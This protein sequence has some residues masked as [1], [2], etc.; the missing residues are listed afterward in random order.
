MKQPDERHLGGE[1]LRDSRRAARSV[2]D[3]PEPLVSFAGS[4]A[5][6][7]QNIR[8]LSVALAIMIALLILTIIA[9]SAHADIHIDKSVVVVGDLV[10]V[11]VLPAYDTQTLIIITPNTTYRFVGGISES[12]AFIPSQTGEHIIRVLDDNNIVDSASFLVI[13]EN[14]RPPAQASAVTSAPANEAAFAVSSTEIVVDQPLIIY[15]P[16]LNVQAIGVDAPDGPHIYND[17][18]RPISYLPSVAGE[19]H[20]WIQYTNGTRA[21]ILVKVSEGRAPLAAP[22]NISANTPANTP[23][24]APTNAAP[25]PTDQF[26]IPTPT[27]VKR[28]G[29][30]TEDGRLV[31][32][33]LV[34]KKDGVTLRQTTAATLDPTTVAAGEYDLDVRTNGRSLRSVEFR[35]L[36]YS[37]DIHIGLEELEPGMVSGGQERAIEMF[38]IDPS[39]V[40]FEDGSLTFV[41]VGYEL[42]KCAEYDFAARACAGEN[43][44]VMDLTPGQAY[45]IAFNSTDP[46]YSQT[47]YL[48]N[49]NFDADTSG[50][51]TLTE[52]GNAPTFNWV[53][54]D[55]AQSGIA[56]I[57]LSG[58]NRNT[59]AHYRQNWT[60][61]IPAG[62][63]LIG[64]NFSAL[65]RVPQYA[66]S[67]NVTLDIMNSTRTISYC[68]NLTGFTTNTSWASI[69]KNA[70]S[71]GCNLGNF[72]N[73]TTYAFVLRCRMR[74]TTTG[75]EA[76]RWDNASVV[77]WY[78][79]TAAPV[80]RN[81][82]DSPDPV[83]YG[84]K[85]NTTVNITDNIGVNTTI[86]EIN[87]TNFTLTKSTG[88]I[89]YN[90]TFSTAR[91]LGI[92][93]YKVFAN[94]SNSNSITNNSASLNF[95]IRDV[96]APNITLLAPQ[97][98]TYNSSSVLLALYNLSDQVGVSNCSL[99]VNSATRNSTLSPALSTTLNLSYTVA[100]D[101]AYLWN[102]TCN[103]TSD[104]R[105]TTETRLWIRDTTA[106]LI[107][108][109]TPNNTATNNPSV[110]FNYTPQDPTLRNCSLW[111]NFS[112]IWA[113]N[114]STLSPNN[115]TANLFTAITLGHGHYR[116]N[117]QC[118][119][120]ASNNGFN[121]TN[122]TYR[123]DLKAP[124]WSGIA[125]TP[126]SG[127][128]YA[129]GATYQFNIS[130]TDDFVGV[131]TTNLETNFSGSLGNVTPTKNGN[132]FTYTFTDR[133][134]G[135]YQYQWY[136]NDSVGNPNQTGA[137]TYTIAKTA[138]AVNLTLNSTYQNRSVNL[139]DWLNLT[140]RMVTP[141]SGYIE[142]YLDG[143]R[144]NNGTPPLSN[145]TQFTQQKR[146]NVTLIYPTTQNYSEGR[147][148]LFVDVVDTIPPRVSLGNPGIGAVT[149]ST[150]DFYFTPSDN[151]DIGNC[152][153]YIDGTKNN[154]KDVANNVQDFITVNGISD[155]P[156][157]WDVNCSDTSNN[158]A[159]NG[160]P[161]S[162]TVDTTPPGLFDLSAPA[163]GTI[164][165]NLS[166]T[167][168]W[169]QPTEPNFD[170]YTLYID[171]D[172]GF[173]SPLPLVVLRPI[174]NTS[175]IPVLPDQTT[176]YWKVIAFDNASNSRQSTS[177]FNYT[178][179]ATPPTVS[180]NSP[181]NDSYLN[182]TSIRLTYTPNDFTPILN[183]SLYV[184]NTLNQ[185]NTTIVRGAQ[186]NFTL[187]IANN[188]YLWNIRCFDSARN[189]YTTAEYLLVID[190]VP[191]QSFTLTDPGNNS[192]VNTST[193]TY[194]WTATSESHFANYTLEVSDNDTF[195]YLNYTLSATVSVSN[196]SR[197][198]SPALTDGVWYWRATAY[199]RA[200]NSITM[201][202]SFNVDTTPPSA[203]DLLLPY[204]N[205]QSR[206]DL[207]LFQWEQSNDANFANYTLYLS[208][209]PTFAHINYTNGTYSKTAT[210][211]SLKVGQNTTLWWRVIAYDLANHSTNST[212]TF[213]Y[214]P[215][216]LNPNVTLIAPFN[217]TTITTSSLVNFQFNIT[218]VGEI[219]NCSLY[220]DGLFDNSINLP[221][222][223]S[224][225]TI[226]SNQEN[227]P[228]YW[229][230]NCLDKANNT[231]NSTAWNFTMNVSVPGQI[232]YESSAGTGNYTASA[233]INLTYARD[234]VENQVGY[235]I[236]RN[237]LTTAVSASY[238]LN[239]SSMILYNNTIVNFSGV[240]SQTRSD[241]FYVTWKLFII[242]GSGTY[243]I[244]QY[245][246]DST[247]GA[248]IGTTTKKTITAGCTY[249]GGD[250]FYNPGDTL[251]LVIDL[252]SNAPNTQS[253]THY[254]EGTSNSS[255]VFK[256]YKLGVLL[257]NLTNLT[258]PGINESSSYIEQC[259][260][261]CRDGY[262]MSTDVYLQLYNGTAWLNISTTGNL[263]LN[264]TQLNPVSL[265]NH[266]TSS[267]INFSLYGS[268]YSYNNTIR[269]FATSTYDQ[270][271]SAQKNVSV[272]DRLPPNVTLVSPGNNAAYDPQNITFTYTVGDRRL[273]NCSLWGNFSGPWTANQTNTSPAN[274]STNSFTPI[275]L[276]Y[277]VYLWNVLCYD[278]AKNIG[279]RS[280]NSTLYIAGDLEITPGNITLSD[281]SPVEGENLTIYANI[282]NRAN[283]TESAVVVQFWLGDPYA[284]G[285]Q[286]GTD[287][288][289]SL[290]KYGYNLTNVTWTATIGQ[291]DIYVVVDPPNGSGLI[292]ESNENNNMASRPLFISL[293]QVYYG[294]V[295]GTYVLGTSAN[296]TFGNWTLTGEAG[297][298]YI[299]STD[300]TQGINWAYLQALGRN[301]TNSTNANT[302]NDFEELDTLLGTGAYSD[303][304]N[305]TYT[306]GGTPIAVEEFTT[307]NRNITDVPVSDSSTDGNF[308]TGILWDAD[309]SSNSYYDT[310]DKED[311]VFA[312]RIHQATGSANGV[313]DYE[314]KVPSELKSYKGAS[315]TVTFYYEIQ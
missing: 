152:T 185:S 193:P 128:A 282:T 226:G 270:N 214:T 101:G 29:I 38:A 236:I 143:V 52:S 203:F 227:G 263:T 248:T 57:N 151:V 112:S 261:T 175:Y 251:T 241:A 113:L 74:T 95:T 26:S 311:I 164:T 146:Y 54:S 134:A 177:T 4:V 43:V 31:N 253:F 180:I 191:P 65:W 237:T 315:G 260:V 2:T 105:N 6:N 86:V 37:P 124:N 53:N 291:H 276:D 126:A 213:R 11:S 114:Q 76:C 206:D 119:D 209:T 178:T 40:T 159:F 199:D 1:A 107:L 88:D 287:R 56:Q 8:T 78:N 184:N 205:N 45:T 195:S 68:S 14:E 156:H 309:D 312:T 36:K 172:I 18:A 16:T 168:S 42:Y 132:V 200:G 275:Y 5:Y 197:T 204:D 279:M 259:N 17:A 80:L 108:L 173:G 41:A 64:I 118:Y 147:D 81:I 111:G 235:S 280:T 82:A 90:D 35:K 232:L 137:L 48:T 69:T 140:A 87:G 285:T 223:N 221:A 51:T 288:T 135:T 102:I 220:I 190:T 97:N 21:E 183:C 155:G 189:N 273:S 264:G 67:G 231:A 133:A 298:I 149:Y 103:D 63:T 148:S 165:S 33:D 215:D 154:T 83:N 278:A 301:T 98:E 217:A 72:T 127:A 92:Y 47:G 187:Q 125:L 240:F 246:D 55:G 229:L 181:G 294:N 254:W 39:A 310:G 258:D 247:G 208:D 192:I 120:N 94:D 179:D 243:S 307:Y 228:H 28:I 116:W 110:Q 274:Y 27:D 207:P 49:P 10:H 245:G 271:T 167:L 32:A 20:V 3:V 15:A 130:W 269:C 160:T 222:R 91:A 218:D 196:T 182:T 272:L 169:T 70:G 46:L 286:I 61:T 60:L 157:A 305:S 292:I 22:M 9:P 138:S 30:H 66:L 250:A 166:P 306:S 289:V 12:T 23:A 7:T 144:I 210:N 131:N 163:S 257:A 262:C 158:S 230:V 85:V 77:V 75:P 295:S 71:A 255:V 171:N 145:L 293:W 176:W 44:K 219:A 89:Y 303:S 162:F 115:N 201:H 281:N 84:D 100:A 308:T 234:A 25:E 34:W 13:G 266:N 194:T 121:L 238:T 212:S 304:V 302:Q 106:P 99:V 188:D 109:N 62:T 297:N 104:N 290:G 277:G 79:D 239:G 244:C 139:D 123:V 313:V 93:F 242:N 96:Y 296:T 174:T 58:N 186:N 202:P 50:W 225:I 256:G 211:A 24:S 142:L 129:P 198:Q 59:V 150:V 73:G 284:G 268:L 170:N 153:V 224:T 252:Y 136:A 19:H 233:T 216:F 141:S 267:V 249:T 265:G 299:S 314:I 300:T 161:R 283:K 122:F 117:V